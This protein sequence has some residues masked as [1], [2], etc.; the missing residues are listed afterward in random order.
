MERIPLAI[1]TL[2]ADLLDQCQASSDVE[3][4]LSANIV[5][6]PV[7]G[8]RYWYLQ[9]SRKHG[10]GKR[11]REYL[12]PVGDKELS[13]RVNAFKEAK[14]SFNRRKQT[15][16][17]IRTACSYHTPKPVADLLQHL[18][19]SRVMKNSILLGTFSF[20]IYSAVL[21]IKFPQSSLR[22]QDIDISPLPL[23][24]SSRESG[25]IKM[26]LFDLLK[27]HDSSFM[28]IP[29]LNPKS[30]STSFMNAEGLRIDVLTTLQGEE[31]GPQLLSAFSCYGHPQRFL[32][33]LFKD[34]IPAIMLTGAGI[35]TNIPEPARF[36]WHKLILAGRRGVHE[37]SKKR[38]DLAQASQLIEYF[39]KY[40]SEKLEEARED[41]VSRGKRWAKALEKGIK[42]LSAL[43]GAK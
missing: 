27:K 9:P 42:A 5:E 22:T 18:D 35:L 36:A 31:K 41:L 14:Y 38:K 26:P 16:R 29:P 11:Q 19:E 30:K 13:L 21:G 15:V 12:G 32:D 33:Y 8:K 3:W 37:E 17:A 39:E 6:V 10:E 23:H 25:A 43:T 2:Y 1:H 34:T 20:Q 40:D 24:I 7:K 4:P 28:A